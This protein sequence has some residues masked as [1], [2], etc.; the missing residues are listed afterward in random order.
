MS[1]ALEKFSYFPFPP[2]AKGDR[3]TR[4]APYRPRPFAKKRRRALPEN[5]TDVFRFQQQTAIFPA[6]FFDIIFR[7]DGGNTFVF[8]FFKRHNTPNR[9]LRAKSRSED[10]PRAAACRLCPK[11]GT[12]PFLKIFYPRKQSISSRRSAPYSRNNR[13]TARLPSYN[14]ANRVE[15]SIFAVASPL[16][17]LRRSAGAGGRFKH[18]L[19]IKKTAA[20]K[21]SRKIAVKARAPTRERRTERHTTRRGKRL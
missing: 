20:P 7:F 14:A 3:F 5:K 18:L 21:A 10:P 1:I 19:T 12:R 9:N 6:C 17:V 4:S 2:P 11:T 13:G 16:R 8:V 15:Y